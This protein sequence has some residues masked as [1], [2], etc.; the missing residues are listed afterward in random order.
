MEPGNRAGRVR[1]YGRQGFGPPGL[2]RRNLASTCSYQACS[3]ARIAATRPGCFEARSVPWERMAVRRRHPPAVH[4]PRARRN[5]PGQHLLRAGYQHRRFSQPASATTMN[6]HACKTMDGI[7]PSRWPL[8]QAEQ[9]TPGL[10]QTA[11]WQA[12]WATAEYWNHTGY[13]QGLPTVTHANRDRHFS[14]GRGSSAFP[15]GVHL[16]DQS[17]EQGLVP[18][19]QGDVHVARGIG[20]VVI[21]FIPSGAW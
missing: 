16:G 14:A 21:E 9:G 18:G 17:V 5:A 19:I 7:L 20:L 12:T 1:P 2:G 3:F 6:C 13:E 4:H 8:R 10:H 15:S 11:C